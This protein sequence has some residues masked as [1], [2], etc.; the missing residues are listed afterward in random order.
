MTRAIR[1]ALLDTVQS[2]QRCGVF[3][4]AQ[5][6]FDRFRIRLA[7]RAE[8]FDERFGTDTEGKVYAW[9]LQR[10]RTEATYHDNYPYEATSARLIR[11]IIRSLPISPLEFVFVDIGC[12]KGRALLVASEFSFLKI[13]GVE[14]SLDLYKIASSNTARFAARGRSRSGCDLR[15]MDAAAYEFEDVPLVVFLFNPFGAHTFAHVVSRLEESA[16][17]KRRDIFV[18]Y[19]NPRHA[20]RLERSP[21]F[22]KLQASGSV[23]RPWNRYVVYRSKPSHGR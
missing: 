23:L 5:Y 13:V 18:I 21:A 4:A 19:I 3:G 6:V 8:R 2:V 11:K 16:Y 10:V 17:R 7:E 15:L 12:G 20:R 22:T 1:D 9:Q 14:I